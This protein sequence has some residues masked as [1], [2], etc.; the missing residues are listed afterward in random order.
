MRGAAPGARRRIGSHANADGWPVGLTLRLDQM[1][2]GHG[3]AGAGSL[4]ESMY[5]RRFVRGPARQ[6]LRAAEILRVAGRFEAAFELICAAG[7]WTTAAT[8]VHAR[9]RRPCWSRVGA[10]TLR[11][12]LVRRA[13]GRAHDRVPISRHDV[14]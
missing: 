6:R 1:C 4:I 9:M 7:D 10:K 8:L 11:A 14:A 3:D 12:C 5:R 13:P 2:R